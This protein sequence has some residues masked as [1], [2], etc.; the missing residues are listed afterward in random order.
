MTKKC[1]KGKCNGTTGCGNSGG[2][3]DKPQEQALYID[4][5][6]SSGV[7]DTLWLRPASLTELYDVLEQHQEQK[8]RMVVGNT[9]TGTL[10]SSENLRMKYI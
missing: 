5:S 3:S 4:A 7:G 9:S 2:Y 10:C 1:G 8:V 6:S